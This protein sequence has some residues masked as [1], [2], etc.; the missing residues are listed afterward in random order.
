MQ[1]DYLEFLNICHIQQ[2]IEHE[3]ETPSRAQIA[4]HLG[5]SRTATSVIVQKLLQAGLIRELEVARKGRGRPG[6]PLVLN[7]SAWYGIGAAFYSLQWTFVIIDLAGHLVESHQI[8]VLSTTPE[9]VVETLLEGLAYI[10]QR[11]PEQMLPAVGIGAPGLVDHKTGSIYRADDFGWTKSIPLKEIVEKE[12]GLRAYILNRYWTNGLAEIRNG[13]HE[14]SKNI[15]YLGIGSG[16]SG[17]IYLDR[18]LQNSTRYR[19]GHMVIDANGPRCGCGQQG[20]LQALASEGALLA[21][22]REKMALD[23]EFFP[24]ARKRVL[25][26][27]LITLLADEGNRDAQLCIDYIAKSLAI[28][29]CTLANVIAPDEII[30]GGPLG[31]SSYYLIDQVRALVNERLLD[32]QREEIQITKGYHDLYGP[33]VGAALYMIEH[34]MELLFE[35]TNLT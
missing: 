4:A 2:A 6:T 8:G 17:S 30:I 31:G 26:G 13:A 3:L 22:A 1:N 5:L 9:E 15:V 33:A 21:F 29:V 23:P 16:I 25:T 24:I 12:T 11:C 10:R 20:C 14:N 18:K 28:A 7:E 32:W 19:L 34:K 27:S 35:P